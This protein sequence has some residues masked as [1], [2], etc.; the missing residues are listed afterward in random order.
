MPTIVSDSTLDILKPD[1]LT[2][3]GPILVL[4]GGGLNQ[5]FSQWE[6]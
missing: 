3:V 2:P 5:T 4:S 6:V 1:K